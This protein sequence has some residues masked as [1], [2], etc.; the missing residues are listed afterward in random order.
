MLNNEQANN[1]YRSYYVDKNNDYVVTFIDESFLSGSEGSDSLPRVT[2]IDITVSSKDTTVKQIAIK[3]AVFNANAE[4]SDPV[5]TTQTIT[6]E[7][8][9]VKESDISAMLSTAIAKSV[10]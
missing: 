2:Q 9:G 4:Y 6:T 7:I 1:M 8:G 10:G 5:N 3:E